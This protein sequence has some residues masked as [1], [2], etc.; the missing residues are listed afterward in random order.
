MRLIVSVVLMVCLSP[1]GWAT[2][3]KE[4]VITPSVMLS[5]GDTPLGTGTVIKWKDTVYILTAAHVVT[6]SYVTVERTRMD[7]KG[8]PVTQT[9]RT[10]KPIDVETQLGKATTKRKAT[11]VW[12]DEAED[13]ALLKLNEVKGLSIAVLSTC[14]C[15][16]EEGA[17]CWYC[18]YGGGMKWNLH[19]TIINRIDDECV[20]VNGG[21]W[22]GHSGSGLFVKRGNQ[23]QLVGVVVELYDT[24]NPRAAVRVVKWSNVLKFLDSLPSK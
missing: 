11:I 1:L 24:S 18:G 16:L 14:K 7:W 5:D 6:G 23:Y 9:K 13:L 22:Y 20:W 21:G 2:P 19:R 4:E 10:V 12:Y 3:L 15:C 8:E 17:D